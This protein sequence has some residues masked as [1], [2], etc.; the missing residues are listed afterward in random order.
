MPRNIPGN[1][2]F[3]DSLSIL[4]SQKNTRVYTA[5]NFSPT[6]PSLPKT[7]IRTGLFKIILL[8][9][10]KTRTI[11]LNILTYLQKNGLEWFRSIL[12][13]IIFKEDT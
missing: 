12:I 4:Y 2:S 5:F 3:G 10:F 8:F 1:P 11:V 7:V 6:P 13:K 9:F